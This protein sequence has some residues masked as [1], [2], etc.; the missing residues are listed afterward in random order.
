MSLFFAKQGVQTVI[1]YKSMAADQL[2]LGKTEIDLST[3]PEGAVSV[4]V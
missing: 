4:F 3:L 2:A 1:A